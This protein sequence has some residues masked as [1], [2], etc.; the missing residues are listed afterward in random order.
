P[1][2]SEFPAPRFGSARP[3]RETIPRIVSFFAQ[4]PSGSAI[5][6]DPWRGLFHACAVGIPRAS[7][8]LGAS[9]ARNDPPDR[10]VFRAGPLRLRHF[11]GPLAGPFSCL[12][13]RN[14][15]RLALA[16][17]VRRAKRSP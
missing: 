13:R 4:D 15:P 9:G 1:A 12:R 8:W 10:F 14:S 11:K 7:L 17:R 6:K 3:A 5:L 16:R 2:P